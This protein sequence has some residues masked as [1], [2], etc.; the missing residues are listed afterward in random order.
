[1]LTELVKHERIET[2]LPKAKMLKYEMERMV[3]Y[4]KKGDEFSLGQ[5]QKSFRVSFINQSPELTIPKMTKII[6]NR[7]QDRKGGYVRILKN[8]YRS[9]GSDRAPL[10][11]IELVLGVN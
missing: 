8:G 11:L 5:L 9:S 4:A 3:N 10:A 2:T 6:A 7:Y 1:M